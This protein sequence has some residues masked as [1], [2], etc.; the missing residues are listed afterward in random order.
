MVRNE[1][2]R[3][4]VDRVESHA[5]STDLE[6]Q[7]NRVRREPTEIGYPQLYDEPAPRPEMRSGIAEALDLF[8]LACQVRDHVEDQIH[9]REDAR[10]SRGHEVARRDV[11]VVRSG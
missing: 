10:D 2:L 9:E 6:R 4:R 5:R 3:G 1:L 11:D 7:R 8:I